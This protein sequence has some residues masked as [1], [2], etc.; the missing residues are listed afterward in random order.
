[1]FAEENAYSVATSFRLSKLTC[2]RFTLKRQG[3]LHLETLLAKEF[4]FVSGI[5][6][7]RETCI[8]DGRLFVKN[9]I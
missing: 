2:P 5:L 6:T 1:M 7:L 9:T 4:R 3:S 8:L